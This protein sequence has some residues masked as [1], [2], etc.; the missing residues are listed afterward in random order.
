MNPRDKSL[1]HDIKLN[2][3]R[4]FAFFCLIIMIFVSNIPASA[5]YETS[6]EVVRQ[7][8]NSYSCNFDGVKHHFILDLPEKSEGAPL[9]LMLPG[10]GNTAES[11]RN[12][13]HFEQVANEF[14]YAVVYV[15]GAPNPNDRFSSIGWNSG[16]GIEGNDDV[17]FLVS[18]AN[19]LQKEY[20][21]DEKRTFAVGFSNGAFMVHRLAMEAGNIF[22][23]CVSVAGMMPAKIWENR[24]AENDVS[25]FQISGEKDD[26]VPKN[27]DGSAA[28]ARDPA[29]EEVMAYWAESNGLDLCE[30]EMTGKGS[31]LT[32]CRSGLTRNQVWNLLI[33]DGRHSWPDINFTSIDT[34]SLI[35]EFFE[36]VSP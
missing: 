22:S 8:E 6:P 32:K 2:G 1:H 11:F 33:K 10:Y 20:A 36:T 3:N 26:V 25:F 13:V 21:F 27:R 31:E 18:L 24:N 17:G 29:I 19:Y 9:V 4:Y 16:I 5:F 12:T 28:Y 35:L 23:A 7:E 30:T 15:S 14:G 34:N